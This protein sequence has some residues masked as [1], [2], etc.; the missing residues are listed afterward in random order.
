MQV[1]FMSRTIEL[2]WINLI[3]TYLVLYI[4]TQDEYSECLKSEL[5]W[6]LD[7]S[8]VSP[9]QT[10]WISDDFFYLKFELLKSNPNLEF[11]FQTLK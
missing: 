2:F 3:K 1:I 8:N 7:S 10:V 5:V 6:T 9:F 4:F 11:G